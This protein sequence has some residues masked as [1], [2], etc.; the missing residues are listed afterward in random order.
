MQWNFNEDIYNICRKLLCQVN[1][2][3]FD[4]SQLIIRK[5]EANMSLV[6][7][8]IDIAEMSEQIMHAYLVIQSMSFFEKQKK[9]L[10]SKIA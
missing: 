3:I 1:I 6:K 5:L 7:I 8:R 2:K 4:N 10:S 9:L